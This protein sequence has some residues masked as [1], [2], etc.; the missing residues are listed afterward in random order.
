[1]RL[2]LLV[3]FLASAINLA[4]CSTMSSSIVDVR[5][6][7]YASQPLWESPHIVPVGGVPPRRPVGTSTPELQSLSSAQLSAL[8]TFPGSLTVV[9]QTRPGLAMIAAQVFASELP[10]AGPS[11]AP[12]PDRQ[13]VQLPVIAALQQKGT[14]NLL[15]DATP[16]PPDI[17]KL[18][19]TKVIVGAALDEALTTHGLKAALSSK[20][21]PGDVASPKDIP[22]KLS[23]RDF[24]EFG[25]A[26]SGSL[27]APYQRV[28]ATSSA[29]GSAQTVAARND[30]NAERAAKIQTCKDTK[31]LAWECIFRAYMM[32]YFNGEFVDRNGGSY[33]KPKLGLTITNETITAAAAIFLEA[34][35]DVAVIDGG[36]RA[37]IVYSDDAFVSTPKDLVAT[38]RQG[39]GHFSAPATYSYVVTAKNANGET[40]QSTEVAVQVLA[41]TDSVALAWSKASGATG[42]NIYRST[43]AG[44]YN[45]PA[46]LATVPGVQFIDSG[47]ATAVGAPPSTNTTGKVLWV[48]KA[49]KMPT[50]AEL[51]KGMQLFTPT[52]DPGSTTSAIPLVIE[53]TSSKS[54][55][56]IDAPRLCVVRLLGG[57]AGDAA[58]P[59]TGMIVRALGGANLGFTFGLGALGKLSFG[60]NDTL[61][62]LI[63][64]IVENFARRLTELSVEHVLYGASTPPPALKGALGLA[65]SLESCKGTN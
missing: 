36:V 50:L 57:S 38:R 41:L 5:Q 21:L 4:A 22:T 29:G 49:S 64:T 59:L 30:A 62:K 7:I 19:L 20:G 47:N 58:Q 33:S 45:S 34:L 16:L 23:L 28:G 53:R 48:T 1:M 32:A 46:L 43:I 2:R 12:P 26:L 9:A 63:D 37:P 42:Y 6:H 14:A 51:A 3:L 44:T 13:S 56:N 60:D 54:P 18:R 27:V 24:L 55:S 31:K 17:A 35:F 8:A 39:S 61:T 15:P 52:G 10:S 65:E 40:L 11:P 25:E